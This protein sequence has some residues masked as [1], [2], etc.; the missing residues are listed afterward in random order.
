MLLDSVRSDSDARQNNGSCPPPLTDISRDALTTCLDDAKAEDIVVIDLI[1][2]SD[3]AD[4]M[5]IAS[6]TSRRMLIGL[7]DRVARYMKDNGHGNVH[8]EGGD[9]A[10]WLVIDGGNF[11]LHLFRPEMRE[12]YAL[13]KMWS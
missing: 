7:A 3:V 6:G 13:E 11:I 2:K 1:G 5:A 12:F 4:F 10:D 8:I 9:E